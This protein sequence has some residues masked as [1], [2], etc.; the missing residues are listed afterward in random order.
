MNRRIWLLLSTAFLAALVIIGMAN[1][2][3][4]SLPAGPSAG[5]SAGL[6]A[7]ADTQ[8]KGVQ[9]QAP[10]K[11]DPF[12]IANFNCADISK[13]H[14]DRQLNLRAA[15]ILQKCG[16]APKSLDKGTGSGSSGVPGVVKQ[17][18]SPLL[19][20]TDINL[21]TGTETSPNIVQSEQFSWSNGNTTVVA[22]NDSRF[23]N[24]NS[25]SGASV[26]T[27]GGATF[28]RLTK[29]GNTSPFPNT[30]GDPVVLYDPVRAIW[31]TVWL[32][33]V[34][35]CGG[36]GGYKSAT[37]AIADS[38]TANPHFCVHAGSGDDR[39]S[40]WAD[41]NP[42]SPNYGR[43]YI[44]W[45]DFS[46]GS[47]ALRITHSDDGGVTWSSPVNITSG[48][49]FIR[50]VQITGDQLGSGKIYGA[51]MDEGGGSGFG[52]RI[53]HMFSSTDGG[54]TWTDVVMGAPFYG[55]GRATSGYFSLVFSTIWRHEGWGQNAALGNNVY[56]D[57]ASCGQGGS[58]NCGSATDHGDIY[59]QKSTTREQ[60][61]AVPSS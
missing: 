17:L 60:L 4:A 6:P 5:P 15:A 12:G 20:G 10:S 54:A 56:Y 40:G 2:A 25:F 51:A 41:S 55:P 43:V 33:G 13:Y 49:T 47:G 45:N 11:D 3:S 44:S 57:Y 31:L 27:D 28:T 35:G 24:S 39:E 46:I 53:N 22:F 36:L 19:G 26:S 16:M 18:T 34:S 23:A 29:T 38:W 59:F 32:D 30:F 48:S 8:G 50:D 58:V 42:A 9:A 61:G 1:A 52:P 37:P 21:V 7:S 14:V